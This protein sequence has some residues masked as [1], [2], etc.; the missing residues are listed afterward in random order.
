MSICAQRIEKKDYT[1]D[2]D[3]VD[4]DRLGFG[5]NTSAGSLVPGA[6]NCESERDEH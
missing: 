6:L 1:V 2:V 5:D 3:E 4:K